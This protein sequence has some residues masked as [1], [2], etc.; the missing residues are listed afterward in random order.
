MPERSSY[1]AGAPCWVDL[2]A[3][4][5][6]SARRFYGAAL[7]WEFQ[8]NGPEYGHYTTCLWKGKPV[9]AL[10]P[11]PPGAE[12]LR[13]A[14]N[15][16]LSAPELEATVERVEQGGGTVAMGP[17][18]IP[19]AGRL[20]FAFDPQGA[21][22][23]LWQAGGHTGAG[24]HGEPGAMTWNE[25]NTTAG[26]EADAF[27][28][29]LFPYEQQ[30]IGDG[31]NFDYS[32]WRLPGSDTPVCGR[33]RAIDPNILE[34]GKGKPFWSVYFAVADVD[35]TA[36]QIAALG[37]SV[38]HGPFNSPFGRLCAVL[39]PSGAHFTVITLAR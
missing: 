8:D 7:G 2:N 32:S 29:G 15:V 39:D 36:R 34:G 33:N 5:L 6:E 37:G 16:Y 25:L 38:L 9:A 27:Y 17:H 3:P 13:P 21:S 14:W 10:M 19:G 28:R 22:F 30:Q 23:G 35:V 11:P 1:P 24:L 26:E 12:G 4:D 31:V 18:E 20:A